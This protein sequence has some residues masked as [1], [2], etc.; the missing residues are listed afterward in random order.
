MRRAMSERRLVIFDP[1]T[2]LWRLTP[3]VVFVVL[4]LLWTVSGV[5][6][7][8]F[9]MLIPFAVVGSIPSLITLRRATVLV[10]GGC[11][12]QLGRREI[13]STASLLGLRYR[14]LHNGREE[15]IL[16]ETP[17]GEVV[18]MS[19]TRVA[20]WASVD[21]RRKAAGR[22]IERLASVCDRTLVKP[23]RRPGAS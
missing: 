23:P 9:L 15:V 16:A 19:Q 18:L 8:N 21:R 3:L 22:A 20:P 13:V 6:A 4:A 17:M 12:R 7:E 14:S 10:S 11:I 5:D 1:A 2:V